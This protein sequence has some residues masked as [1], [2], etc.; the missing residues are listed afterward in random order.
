MRTGDMKVREN[1]PFSYNSLLT[2]APEPW[3]GRERER[4]REKSGYICIVYIY[5]RIVDVYYYIIHRV[6]VRIY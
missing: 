2:F 1:L 4:E 6:R 3:L 5:N